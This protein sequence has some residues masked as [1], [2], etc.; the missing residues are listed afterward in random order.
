MTLAQQK[1][2]LIL[3]DEAKIVLR[4]ASVSA[5][6]SAA[7]EVYAKETDDLGI[8]IQVKRVDGDHLVLVRWEYILSIDVLPSERRPLGLGV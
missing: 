3:D 8:W 1:L 7:V 6:D 4:R 5:P 2:A